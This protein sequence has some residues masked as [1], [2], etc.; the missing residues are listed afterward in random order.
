MLRE[1]R[2]DLATRKITEKE[3]DPAIVFGNRGMIA[4]TLLEEVDPQCD[5]LGDRNKLVFATGLFAGYQYPT[6]N[7]LS[8]GAKSPLTGTIKE[9]NSGGTFAT[10]LI[11]HGIKKMVLE[12]VPNEEDWYI[13]RIDKRGNISFEQAD[14]Y[15]FK[16]TYET[17][18][19]LREKYGDNISAAVIGP[20]G[21]RMYKAASIQ[22]TDFSL[23]HPSRACGRGGMGAV[24]GSKHI[25]AFVIEK[26]EKKAD[27]PKHD[28]AKVKEITKEYFLMAANDE[29]L[30]FVKQFGTT[31]TLAVTTPSNMLPVKNFSGELM[32]EENQAKFNIQTYSGR[33]NSFG[34]KQGVACQAGCPIQCSNIYNDEKGQLVTSG[35]E[36]ETVALAGPNCGIY[37]WDFVAEFDRICDDVGVDTIDV[38]V[39]L[40]IAMDAGYIKFGDVDGARTLLKEM[41]TGS[42]FGKILG[43][44]ARIA[45]GHL[46]HKRIPVCKGQALP[47][48]DP[49]AIKGGGV[50]YM[51]FTQGA[52]HTGGLTL[53]VPGLDHS[54]PDIQIEPAKAMTYAYAL[55]DNI[56][57]LMAAGTVLAPGSIEKLTELYNAIYGVNIGPEALGMMG[58]QTITMEREFNKR[59]GFTPKDDIIPQFFREEPISIAPQKFDVD[60]KQIE[61]M[62]EGKQ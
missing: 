28:E 36:Y 39:A 51:T 4:K 33:I 16:G 1:I 52:D 62:W 60:Q 18:E 46:K 13:I 5:P 55:A 19:K 32:T 42:N 35:L 15:R 11:N 25:K 49:R 34:G 47:A 59:A 50:A 43:D 61:M 58:V 27:F 20:G 23:G 45:G 3:F 38:A 22:V 57:C 37:D 26:A 24:M 54:N 48:Y 6:G 40:S 10:Y 29:G 41:A 14:E 44:G 9:S 30:K 53:Q 2:I 7:R 17:V 12:N 21:E 56:C 8:V 31:G